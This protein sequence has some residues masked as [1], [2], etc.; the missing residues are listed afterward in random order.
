MAEPAKINLAVELA[1]IVKPWQPRVVETIDDYEIKVAKLL[2]ETAFHANDAEDELFM[3]LKGRLR[4]AFRDREVELGP[5][6]MIA[7][8]RGQEHKPVAEEECE[9]LI[10]ER[11]HAVRTSD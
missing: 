10:F 11:R 6:E 3:V 8:R 1:G 2:G 9:V 4:M 5:G 7:V